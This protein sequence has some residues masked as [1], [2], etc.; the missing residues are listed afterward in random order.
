MAKGDNFNYRGDSRDSGKR[1]IEV[2]TES[3]AASTHPDRNEDAAFADATQLERDMNAP[4]ALKTADTEGD[5]RMIAESARKQLE[6]LPK[7]KEKNVFGVLDGVSGRG[8]N[9]SGAVASRLASGKMAEIMSHMPDDADAERAVRSIEAAIKAAHQAVME[10]KSGRPDLK[11][12]ATT[13]DLL[14]TVDNG[15]GTFDIAYGH[16][17]DSR[18]YVMDGETGEIR[19]ETV[20]DGMAGA[21]MREGQIDRAQYDQIMNA[22]DKASLPEDLQFYYQYRN[23]VDNVIGIDKPEVRVSTGIIKAKKGD[24]ILISSDGIHD[25]LTADQIAEVLRNGGGVKELA[26]AAYGIASSGEGRAKPDDITGTLIELGGERQEKKASGEQESGR[27]TADQLQQWNREVDNASKEIAKLQRLKEVAEELNKPQIN[28]GKGVK[29]DE[30]RAI[31]QI[32]GVE[33]IEKLQREW[34]LYSL[35]RRKVL[36]QQD[37]GEQAMKDIQDTEKKVDDLQQMHLAA[38]SVENRA[39]GRPEVALKPRMEVIMAVER[40]AKKE[41]PTALRERLS[42]EMKAARQQL[43][44]MEA[45][46]PQAQ[47][48]KATI[49][50][51][52]RLQAEKM[53]EMKQKEAAEAKKAREAIDNIAPAPS[54][55]VRSR[56]A[57][58]MPVVTSEQIENMRQQQEPPAPNSP[59]KKKKGFFGKLF[60]GK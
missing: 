3:M 14:K 16:A 34:K 4:P 46:N 17:G 47:E 48:L 50:E 25:N 38:L 58:Q 21:A 44:S 6:L 28:A 36:L 15:D 9:G 56:M 55:P 57:R 52:D 26:Q 2:S 45:S 51:L 12:M 43:A 1:S 20:D 29:I 31:E 19:C 40:M 23:V 60:G 13:A 32:G 49:A 54:T 27:Q 53:R 10:Y 35:D 11:E 7:L 41:D 42:K 8:S 22:P 5:Q 37:I 24:R 33:G 59:P 39:K 18:I 30:I